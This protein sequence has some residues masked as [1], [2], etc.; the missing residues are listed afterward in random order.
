MLDIKFIKENL[1]LVKKN[2]EDR[3]VRVDAD[4]VVELYN[5]KNSIQVKLDNLRKNRNE[6][7][8]KMKSKLSDSDTQKLIEEGRSLKE[9]IAGLEEEQ[10]TVESEF[11]QEALKIPNL[12]HPTTPIG[13]TDKDSVVLRRVRRNK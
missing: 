2:I 5:K 4:L 9:E 3:N 13:V 8:Q 11:F 6:N 10:K 1:E 7:A 12:T